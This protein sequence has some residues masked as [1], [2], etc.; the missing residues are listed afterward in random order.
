MWT[1]N[2]HH[3]PRK[4]GNVQK[5]WAGVLGEFFTDKDNFEVN[6]DDPNLSPELKTLMLA[7]CLMVDV[8]YFENNH[9]TSIVDNF[10]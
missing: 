5:V 3:G 4:L 7:T 9:K 6:F 1:F 10:T 2:F 8:V